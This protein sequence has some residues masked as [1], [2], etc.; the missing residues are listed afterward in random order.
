MDHRSLNPPPRKT[1][2]FQTWMRK[3]PLVSGTLL[4]ETQLLRDV[5]NVRTFQEY[6]S[7]CCYYDLFDDF[8]ERCIECTRSNRRMMSASLAEEMRKWCIVAT[9]L[10]GR[11]PRSDTSSRFICD[12]LMVIAWN[13]YAG[14]Y[15]RGEL[16]DDAIERWYR[17]HADIARRGGVLNPGDVNV[18]SSLLYRAIASH[19]TRAAGAAFFES[20]RVSSAAHRST[21]ISPVAPRTP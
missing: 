10:Q 11:D 7:H 17:H 4:T 6:V 15:E 9:L 13:T 2:F 21:T 8:E 19:V 20:H 3:G 18:V 1:D 12:R 14:M 16:D 5:S